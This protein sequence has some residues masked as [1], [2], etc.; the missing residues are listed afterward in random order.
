MQ[1]SPPRGSTPPVTGCCSA[2]AAMRQK[3]QLC[4]KPA[5]G[6]PGLATSAAAA[7][8]SVTQNGL[9]ARHAGGGKG[10][11][12]TDGGKPE[13]RVSAAATA[14][15]A[16]RGAWN[17]EVKAC[18]EPHTE[19][20][21][22]HASCCEWDCCCGCGRQRPAGRSLLT[23]RPAARPTA[24]WCSWPEAAAAAAGQLLLRCTRQPPLSA[25]CVQGAG[26]AYWA[27]ACSKF[28]TSSGTSAERWERQ[29]D[30]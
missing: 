26:A 16:G 29:G 22:R 14:D 17:R 3:S 8:L 10:C 15:G 11:V 5:G 18:A 9:H 1:G 19:G 24:A 6:G 13:A 7:F 21:P 28:S 23:L 30:G 4:G 2:A 25:G 27:A 20:A 12:S